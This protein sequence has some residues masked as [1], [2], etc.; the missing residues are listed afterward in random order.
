MGLDSCRAQRLG[1]PS[2]ALR[3]YWVTTDLFGLVGG[4]WGPQEPQRFKRNQTDT[5]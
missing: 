2:L 4:A 1:S 5:H 3:R